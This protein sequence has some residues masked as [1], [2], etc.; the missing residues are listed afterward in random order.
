MLSDA[1]DTA[2]AS[3]HADL[4]V[5][6]ERSREF[7]SRV[8]DVESLPRECA[9]LESSGG[10][11]IDPAQRAVVYELQQS[12]FD[13]R[14]IPAPPYHRLLL[15][16]RV[17]HE[18]GH[19]AHTAKIVRIPDECRTTYTERRA[20]FG[21][22]FTRVLR[23]VPEPFQ[24]ALEPELRELAQLGEMP[25]VLARKTLCRVGDYLANMV[26]ARLIPGEEMQAYV[27]TNVRHHLDE[28]LGLVS[29]LARHAY[30]IHYL[31]L[32][33]L[34]RDYFYRTSR[35]VDHFFATGM[36]REAEVEALFDAAGE[37][38]ACYAIDES[39]LSLA[40]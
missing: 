6:D 7:L 11:Y 36:L 35:F 33:G 24:P 14:A 4:R 23:S 40:H 2:V 32:V 28:K 31:D 8:S 37:V 13:T 9:V 39:R 25:K 19:I 15:G 34:P 29:E 20:E 1:S 5:I 12:I 18:W 17:M 21:E 27:R 16:A 10:T 3:L 26:S 38:L 22:T 30:E